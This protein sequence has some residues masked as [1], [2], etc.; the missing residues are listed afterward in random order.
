MSF[1]KADRAGGFSL[2]SKWQHVYS[3]IQDSSK[4]PSQLQYCCGQDVLNSSSNLQF[5]LF[6]PTFL[7]T[8]PRVPTTIKITELTDETLF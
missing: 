1:F 3:D 4:H 8:D 2:K 7:G 5:S 6:F